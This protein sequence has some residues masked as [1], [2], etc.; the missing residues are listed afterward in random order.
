MFWWILGCLLGLFGLTIVWGRLEASRLAVSRHTLHSPHLPPAFDGLRVA[1]LSDLHYAGGA[2]VE[3]QARQFVAEAQPDLILFTGDLLRSTEIAPLAADYLA[4]FQAPLGTVAVLGNHDRR[5]SLTNGWLTDELRR[6]GVQV[7]LNENVRVERNGDALWIVGVDDPHKKLDRIELALNGTPPDAFR[8]ML[9]H[10][11]AV[12]RQA[13][14]AGI[15]LM[16]SGH[17]HGG[18]IRLPLVG[19]LHTNTPG[20]PRAFAAGLTRLSDRTALIVSRG[21]GL[22]WFQVRLFCRPEV[23]FI[24][25]RRPPHAA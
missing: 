4:G 17:T 8:I 6:R 9:V 23:V 16:L 22:T 7:L 25:L 11:A 1:H 5:L 21:I 19:P 14:E 20:V 24:E 10:T 15:D 3:R 13:C 18:Q 2:A 12:Y